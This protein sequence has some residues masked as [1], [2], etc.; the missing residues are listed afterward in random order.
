MALI[1]WSIPKFAF[2]SVLVCST[3]MFLHKAVLRVRIGIINSKILRE[4]SL[5]EHGTEVDFRL[6]GETWVFRK[7][8]TKYNL[9]KN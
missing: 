5:P 7:G 3:N 8:V 1:P 6:G 4:C 2:L 9:N